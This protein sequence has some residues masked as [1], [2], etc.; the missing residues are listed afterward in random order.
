MY[1]LLL[2]IFG[3]TYLLIHFLSFL[4]APPTETSTEMVRDV[5]R[6]RLHERRSSRN[7]VHIQ[8]LLHFTCFHCPRVLLGITAN[9]FIYIYAQLLTQQLTGIDQ[10]RLPHRLGQIVRTY[11]GFDKSSLFWEMYAGPYNRKYPNTVINDHISRRYKLL[12][13]AFN[14]A[15]FMSSGFINI[16]TLNL[17]MFS[18][19]E[20]SSC[21]VFETLGI[22]FIR[23]ESFVFI[24]L[25][26]S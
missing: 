20:S 25:D 12:Y 11:S 15:M 19:N 10:N 21:G 26:Q 7:F 24:F 14:H 23:L 3:F 13:N 8:M 9:L 17:S 4:T 6:E 22:R 18:F 16:A 1:S 2:A 5:R